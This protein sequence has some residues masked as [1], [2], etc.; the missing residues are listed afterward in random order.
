MDVSSKLI[1]V[2]IF[3]KFH[4]PALLTLRFVAFTVCCSSKRTESEIARNYGADP[5]N[6]Q[7]FRGNPQQLGYET[8]FIIDPFLSESLSQRK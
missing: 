7:R 3:Q 8:F 6:L 2:V 1:V 5:D 4:T